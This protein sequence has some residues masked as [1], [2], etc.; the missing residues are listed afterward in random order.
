[1]RVSRNVGNTRS[2]SECV[3]AKRRQLLF[4]KPGTL[5]C[6]ADVLIIFAQRRVSS[7]FTFIARLAGK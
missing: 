4:R 7:G 6:I 5:P 1:M 3:L 2:D